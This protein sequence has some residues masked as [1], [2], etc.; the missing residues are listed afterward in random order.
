MLT[1][2]LLSPSVWVPRLPAGVDPVELL[3]VLAAGAVWVVAVVDTV[4]RGAVP[5]TPAG[6]DRRGPVDR[7]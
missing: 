3:R 4:R 6:A 2:L 5:P 7:W 1:V